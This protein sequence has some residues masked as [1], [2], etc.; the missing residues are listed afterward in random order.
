MDGFVNRNGKSKRRGSNR[1]QS[2]KQVLKG[3]LSGLPEYSRSMPVEI[4]LDWED[5]VGPLLC[6]K[7]FPSALKNS[8]LTVCASP[9][10]FRVLNDVKAHIIK[11]LN[12]YE[13]EIEDIEFKKVK[14]FNARFGVVK[15]RDRGHD[16]AAEKQFELSGNEEAEVAGMVSCI[17]DRRLRHLVSEVIRRD[18]IMKKSG[19]L[20]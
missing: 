19:R 11:K 18:Y 14:N 2:T 5:I 12:D 20:S 3:M 13:L 4:F 7:C 16:G 6:R 8:I 15:D 10:W 17:E 1:F 9:E